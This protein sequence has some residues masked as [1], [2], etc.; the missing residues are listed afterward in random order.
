M[1]RGLVA[2]WVFVNPSCDMTLACGLR[3]KIQRTGWVI[4]TNDVYYL[5]LGYTVADSG[6]FLIGIHKGS[7]AF[8]NPFRVVFPP[9]TK[10]K[11]LDSFLYA[12]FNRR[13]YAASV[14]LHHGDF[15]SSGCF[16]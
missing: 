9:I 16:A 12:P 5:D 2:V 15:S 3:R 13:E 10:P 8:H 6:T 1:K 7:T 14:S 4:S 11:P